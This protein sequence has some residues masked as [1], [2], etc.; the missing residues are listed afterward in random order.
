MRIRTTKKC[1]IKNRKEATVIT[2]TLV[3]RAFIAPPAG[4]NAT[5][6]DGT[7][8][9]TWLKPAT[10]V[11]GYNV[12][13][14]GVRIA[15]IPQISPLFEFP[16]FNDSLREPELL[17][18]EIAELM[19]LVNVEP[20]LKTRFDLSSVT[21]DGESDLVGFYLTYERF[22]EFAD[23]AIVPNP[24]DVGRQFVISAKVRDEQNLII[25]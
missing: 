20:F 9:I 25:E 15:F 24:I 16:F 4:V 18:S 19:Y 5:L 2:N 8:V 10:A 22:F 21:A 3:E 7:V 6:R 11:L 13:Q 12:Y 1:S 14:N 17:C 23:A